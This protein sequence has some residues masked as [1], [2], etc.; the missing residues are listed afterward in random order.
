MK[1]FKEFILEKIELDKYYTPIKTAQ[2]CINKTYDIIGRGNITET[3]E[4]S[5][6]DGSFSNL[7]PGCIA[8]DIKPEK[9]GIIKQDFL[10]LNLPYK[11][12]RLF[13]GNP[14]FGEKN[15]LSV[16]FFK[17][18]VKMGDYVSF[19]LPI[20]QLNN[21]QQLFEF[22]LVYS[23]DL[24]KL[25]YS[26]KMVHCCLN[27]YKRN[28]EG[29]LRKPSFKLDKIEIVSYVRG[30]SFPPVNYDYAI[31]GWGNKTGQEIEYPG[32]YA[33]EFYVIVNDIESKNK[34]LEF[35]RKVDWEK[36]YPSTAAKK[37]QVWKIEKLLY[38]KFPEL[39]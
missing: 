1:T 15:K 31:C 29:L 7:I 37:L 20:S 34:V 36:I 21:Q 4:P 6:G 5:A 8:Y 12:G 23:E 28:E 16:A 13:I 32:Q 30:K 25:P 3:I 22:E 14:P 9:E 17:Q 18:C 35:L 26:G 27:I 39:K 33:Q 11:K 24:G 10:K 19:V 2:Y 38:D